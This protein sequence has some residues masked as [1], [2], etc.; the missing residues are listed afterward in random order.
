MSATKIHCGLGVV[1]GQNVTS[2]GTVRQWHKMF[3]DGW[4]NVHNVERRGWPFAVSDDLVQIA[5]QKIYE[6]QNFRVNLLPQISYTV[7]Y[8]IITVRLGYHKFC[9][10]W[11]QKMFTGAH[12]TQRMAL[13]QTFLYRAILER[14]WWIF[15]HTVT[16]DKT[17]LSFVNVKTKEQSK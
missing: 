5:K 14:L 8:K 13:A 10:R 4:I 9:A 12:K 17:W 15:N 2:E 1:Y 16:G 3:K 11:V 7:L 6:F